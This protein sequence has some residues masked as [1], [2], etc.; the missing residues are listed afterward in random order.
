MWK[1]ISIIA[2][3]L[4][5]GVSIK[6]VSDGAQVFSKD[7]QQVVV[8]DEM[9]GTESTEWQDGFWLGLDIAGPVTGVLIAVG[10][11]GLYKTQKAK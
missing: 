11:L 6:W 8:V 2:F 4:V 9:F 10:V 5:V 1:V 3:V 7:K